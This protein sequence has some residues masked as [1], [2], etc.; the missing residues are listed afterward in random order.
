MIYVSKK[1]AYHDT[2]NYGILPADPKL[3]TLVMEGYCA[4]TLY[5]FIF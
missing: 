4:S 2:L 3:K 5:S 1:E